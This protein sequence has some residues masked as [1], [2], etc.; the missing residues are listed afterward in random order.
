M[1]TA[2]TYK[3]ALYWNAPGEKPVCVME[4]RTTA[5][6]AYDH[7]RAH[8]EQFAGTSHTRWLAEAWH[9]HKAPFSLNAFLALE[10]GKVLSGG[11]EDASGHAMFFC[12][13][14]L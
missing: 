9:G 12:E 5:T 13:R 11:Y 4:A 14:D 2:L 6:I 3:V 8:C 7:C 10:D 1:N